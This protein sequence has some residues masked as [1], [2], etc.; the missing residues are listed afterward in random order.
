[1]ADQRPTDSFP[2]L[3]DV[4]LYLTMHGYNWYWLAFV[5]MI[6]SLLAIIVLDFMRPRGIRLFHQIA[7]VV[8]TT[9]SLAY[10]SM[11]FDLSTSSPEAQ[12]GGGAAFRTI[13]FA[14]YIMW[15]INL[16]LLLLSVLLVTGLSLLEI[17]VTLFAAVVLVLSG[18][19][20]DFAPAYG[21]WFSLMSGVAF[22]CVIHNV[23]VKGTKSAYAAGDAF[24]TRYLLS[25]A[26]LALV[27]L[28]YPA[29]HVLAHSSAL[30]PAAAAGAYGAL[31]VLAQP[32]F[33]LFFLHQL[34][35]IDPGSVCGAIAL[36]DAEEAQQRPRPRRLRRSLPLVVLRY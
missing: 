16:P 18:L 22:G 14:W 13:S 8:L 20:A 25:A 9:A 29:T 26:F 15:I 35:R 6:T 5:C 30:A 12:I 28:G 4:G 34:S 11:A 1:M 33:L 21:R 23:L 32:V 27:L 36:E 19:V 24:G 31:D 7:I 3:L 2:S 17:L 10:F